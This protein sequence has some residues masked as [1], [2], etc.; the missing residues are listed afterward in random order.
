[1]KTSR[2]SDLDVQERRKC[3]FEFVKADSRRQRYAA[4]T[5]QLTFRHTSLDCQ[6]KISIKSLI[7]IQT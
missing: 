6:L 3:V 7:A 5:V 1:M 4:V 2:S